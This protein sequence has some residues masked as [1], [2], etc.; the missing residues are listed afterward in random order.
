VTDA[1]LAQQEI[2]VLQF[3]AASDARVTQQSVD[4][5]QFAAAS[6]A[7]LVMQSIDV[8]I[9]VTPS[10]GGAVGWSQTNTKAWG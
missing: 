8:L 4:V 10:I 6:D 1:R 3:G 2:D 5:L 7:R 9:I